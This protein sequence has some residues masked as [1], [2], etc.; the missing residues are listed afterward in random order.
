MHNKNQR[1]KIQHFNEN[2]VDK[3]LIYTYNAI[4]KFIKYNFFIF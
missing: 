3:K 1:I 4:A 2:L